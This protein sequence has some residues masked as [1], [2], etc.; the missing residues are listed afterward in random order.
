MLGAS[1][2]FS[3]PVM[4]ALAL[5]GRLSETEEPINR[6]Y[7]RTV[8]RHVCHSERC[9]GHIWERVNDRDFDPAIGFFH[10]VPQLCPACIYLAHRTVEFDTETWTIE[11]IKSLARIEDEPPKA[12]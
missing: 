11:G 5:S 3:I 10:D 6:R 9:R 7:W 4:C 1:V 12:A 2:L 8:T